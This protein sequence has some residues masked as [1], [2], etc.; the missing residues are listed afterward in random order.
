MD[1]PHCTKK[2]DEIRKAIEKIYNLESLEKEVI[3][4]NDLREIKRFLDRKVFTT[5]HIENKLEIFGIFPL[6]FEFF[7]KNK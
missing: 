4:K 7:C 1:L 3:K 5:N 2:I 6:Y